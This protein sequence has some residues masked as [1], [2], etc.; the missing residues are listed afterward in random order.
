MES[1]FLSEVHDTS[2]L[3][4]GALHCYHYYILS[5]GSRPLGS[6]P[7]AAGWSAATSC[8]DPFSDA[9]S[10]GSPTPILRAG[11]LVGERRRDEG[12]TPHHLAK[13]DSDDAD[14]ADESPRQATFK[15]GLC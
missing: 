11:V 6:C 8:C 14:Q 9:G 5:T 3:R 2:I 4:T 7:R 13:L 1:S 15:R 10:C 12:F